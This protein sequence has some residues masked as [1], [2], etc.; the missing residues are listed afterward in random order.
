MK[1]RDKILSAALGLFNKEG[2]RAITTN[3]I[4]GHLGISPGNLYYHFRNKEAIIL[5]LFDQLQGGLVKRIILPEDRPITLG[6]KKQYLEAMLEC[7][8]EYR[9]IFRG[10]HGAIAHSE[11]LQ[12]QFRAFAHAC[13]EMIGRVFHGLVRS[14]LMDATEE[15]MKALG[16]NT[17]M[18]LTNWHELIN[19]LIPVHPEPP[20]ELLSRVIY[21]VLLL[22]RGFITPDAL[23]SFKILERSYYSPLPL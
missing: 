6:D 16:L 21:Q 2:E 18:V 22:D 12:Q 19:T 1:T 20:R 5:A 7:L 3:H 10:L 23:E 11:A 13:L 8:W 15:E 17:F 14:G 9:F 4:A